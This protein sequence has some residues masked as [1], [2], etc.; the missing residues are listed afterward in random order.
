MRR[1]AIVVGAIALLCLYLFCL[2]FVHYTETGQAAIMRNF[3]TG[4]VKLDHPGWNL[5][6]P[7]VQAAHIELRPQRVCITTAGR[8][9]SCKLVRFDPEHFKEFV[10]VEGFRYYWWANRL[11]YNWGYDEEYRGFRDL[12]RGHAYG[13]KTYPFITILEVYEEE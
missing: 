4:E 12:L 7:W 11:S 13:A 9:Y 5:S 2:G 8:G 3:V 1:S 10:Q 6:T